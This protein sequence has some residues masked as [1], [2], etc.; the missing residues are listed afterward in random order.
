MMIPLAPNANNMSMRGE[1]AKVKYAVTFSHVLIDDPIV[2]SPVVQCWLI[3]LALHCQ[4][5]PEY[6]ILDMA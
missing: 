5:T 1:S 4:L 2:K 6:W 3:C